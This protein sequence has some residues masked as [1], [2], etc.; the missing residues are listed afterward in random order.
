M[1][2]LWNTCLAGAAD[3]LAGVGWPCP[4]LCVEGLTPSRV[5]DHSGRE[6]SHLQAE[7]RA[8]RVSP[9]YSQP[10]LCRE[11]RDTTLSSRVSGIFHLNR[12]K[13]PSV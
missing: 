6:E 12:R 10:L 11:E 13:V 5:Q 8:A 7:A 4:Q 2:G 1:P 3:L 9:S